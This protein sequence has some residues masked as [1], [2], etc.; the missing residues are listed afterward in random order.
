M[1][2]PNV[3]MFSNTQ[4]ILKNIRRLWH[5]QVQ[6]YG[7]ANLSD[8]LQLRERLEEEP[9]IGRIPKLYYLREYRRIMVEWPSPVHE[10]PLIQLSCLL[11]EFHHHIM[12]G[13]HILV[14]R[15]MDFM[16]AGG[17]ITIPDL[18]LSAWSKTVRTQ[19]YP[20]LVECARPQSMQNVLSK[21]RTQ[22]PEC[23]VIMAIIINITENEQFR[24]PAVDSNI[25][26]YF[27]DSPQILSQDEFIPKHAF[28]ELANNQSS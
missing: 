2:D 14:E 1:A 23:D 18:A 17:T 22:L 25:W 11:G 6:E 12:A 10:Y 27:K 16:G 28:R 20:V 4:D 26:N 15:N 19:R 7:N 13:T 9:G 5:D 24:L 21:F 8:F 3:P